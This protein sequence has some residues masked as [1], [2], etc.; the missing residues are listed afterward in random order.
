[1]PSCKGEGDVATTIPEER[2]RERQEA[3][4]NCEEDALL[5]GGPR[6]DLLFVRMK[7]PRESAPQDW[8]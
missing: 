5:P 8:I 6:P 7:I 3:E 4:E 2:D 1:M